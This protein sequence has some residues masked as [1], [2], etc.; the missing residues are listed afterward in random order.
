METSNCLNFGFVS[1]FLCYKVC[2]LSYS[3]H[4]YGHAIGF[5]IIRIA[6]ILSILLGYY[7]QHPY[8]HAIGATIGLIV[9]LLQF[10]FLPYSLFVSISYGLETSLMLFSGHFLIFPFVKYVT[11]ALCPTNLNVYITISPLFLFVFI[12]IDQIL[13]FLCLFKTG[14]G[15]TKKMSKKRIF[16]SVWYGFL[17]CKTYYCVLF[18]L[19]FGCKFPVTAWILDIALGMLSQLCCVCN[20]VSVV[21]LVC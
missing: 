8:G 5:F 4:P 17:N 18:P 10:I 9:S 20:F 12:I 3:Q 15:E 19:L 11:D 21:C 7:S 16:Q 14:K 2:H 13:C 1:R 6:V